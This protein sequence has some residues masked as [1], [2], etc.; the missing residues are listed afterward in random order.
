MKGP[1]KRLMVLSRCGA[2][3]YMHLLAERVTQGPTRPPSSRLL[4]DWKHGSICASRTAMIRITKSSRRC[5]T[6]R[7]CVEC[8]EAAR[9]HCGRISIF[10]SAQISTGLPG[11]VRD[12]LPFRAALPREN[13]KGRKVHPSWRRGDSIGATRSRPLRGSVV[14]GTSAWLK[15]VDAAM[16]TAAPHRAEELARCD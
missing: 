15:P 7:V 4:L 8:A 12:S 2:I 13:V 11:W 10:Q 6:P 16:R 3:G 5:H 1:T 14:A 9:R